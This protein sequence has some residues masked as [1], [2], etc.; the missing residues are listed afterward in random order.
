MCDGVWL[1]N[2]TRWRIPG[3]KAQMVEQT[4]AFQARTER[5][6]EMLRS[7][8]KFILQ[9]VRHDIRPFRSAYQLVTIS[10]LCYAQLAW[11]VVA[12]QQP[13][14]FLKGLGRQGITRS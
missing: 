2:V 1:R 14:C 10:S 3:M 7:I 8:S 6:V 13:V 9:Q 12:A 4:K 11:F 5:K